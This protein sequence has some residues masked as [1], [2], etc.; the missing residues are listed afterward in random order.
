VKSFGVE[1]ETHAELF[2]PY[3]QEPFPLLGL[4]VRTSGDPDA[5]STTVRRAIW[6]IDRDQPV[7]YVL[8]MATLAG[9]ALAFQR[10]SM[11]LIGAF[12]ALALTLAAVGVYGVLAYLVTQRRREIGIRLALGAERRSVLS[13]IVR[14]AV[15]L[16]AIGGAVGLALAFVLSRVLRTMLYGV[17]PADPVSYGV[18]AVLVPVV[19]VLAS[20]VPG[21]RA[22]RV[23]PMT[24][25]REE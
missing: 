6:E 4:V 2:R 15:S 1:Q 3:T 22:T 17:E 25:L 7:A 9:E 23:D 14:R 16:A 18:A 24:A 10:V 8:P 19:A 20:V 5:L 13:I 11:L 12:A 21:W